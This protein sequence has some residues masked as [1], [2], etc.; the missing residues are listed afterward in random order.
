MAQLADDWRPAF[1]T[2]IEL[3]GET[4]GSDGQQ[5]PSIQYGAVGSETAALGLD[6]IS[7]IC[8]LGIVV[9]G[10]SIMVGIVKCEDALRRIGQGM[11]FALLGL[12]AVCVMRMLLKSA[13][14]PSLLA[15]KSILLWLL[16]IVLAVGVLAYV[17]R[18]ATWK[19]RP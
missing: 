17:A 10:V 8:V 1:V 16:G 15:L 19:L 6:V 5:V 14:V 2:D 9:V 13:L 18:W 7:S 3:A 4:V 12:I 11:L